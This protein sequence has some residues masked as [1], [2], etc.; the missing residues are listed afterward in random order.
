MRLFGFAVL[1][2]GFALFVSSCDNHHSG[3]G[4][5]DGFWQMT[6]VETHG[7]CK[8]ED[9]NNLPMYW[10]IQ[11]DLLNIR[12]EQDTYGLLFR[13]RQTKDS[14]YLFDPYYNNRN[15]SDIKITESVFL[16]PYGI[17]HLNEGFAIEILTSSTM[18]LNS[19]S[20]R[21]AFRKY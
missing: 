8:K 19:D 5:L 11:A 9:F 15:A 2:F 3:N 21:L 10:A 18:I 17:F 4:K 12:Q 7:N 13:F 1:I 16:Y 6:N 20:V 14:L